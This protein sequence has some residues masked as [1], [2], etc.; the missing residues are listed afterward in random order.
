MQKKELGYVE[1]EWTCP[2]CKVRNPGTVTIC[3]GCGTAQPAG[4]KFE[5]PSATELVTDKA[6]IE[7]AK[8]GPDIQCGFCNARNRADAKVCIQCGADL[9]AGKQREAGAVVGAFSST[10]AKPVI[11][12]ACNAENPAGNAVCQKCGAPLA[13]S[14]AP[15]RWETARRTRPDTPP[16]AVWHRGSACSPAAVAPV[17]LADRPPHRPSACVNPTPPRRRRPARP[18]RPSPARVPASAT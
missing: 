10:P 1:L 16:V 17:Q 5:A 11:C 15:P 13:K 4:V 14:V 18:S 12:T 2:T 7:R 9:T 3:R 6:K 8:A